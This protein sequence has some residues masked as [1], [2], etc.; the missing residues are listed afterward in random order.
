MAFSLVA[1]LL[2]YRVFC[3]SNN[4]PTDMLSCLGGCEFGSI[5]IRCGLLG[6]PA[7]PPPLLT[8]LAV[9]AFPAVILLLFILFSFPIV[10]CELWPPSLLQIFMLFHITA[11]PLNTLLAAII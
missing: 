9:V 7:C 5:S 8:V 6:V 11:Y 3:F 10:N 1:A 2:A 4:L